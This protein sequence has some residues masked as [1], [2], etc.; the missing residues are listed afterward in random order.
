MKVSKETSPT[1]I[2]EGDKN[3][4]ESVVDTSNEYE[5]FEL[6]TEPAKRA[7]VKPLP[8]IKPSTLT[9]NLKPQIGGIKK[10]HAASHDSSPTQGS[11]ETAYYGNIG[12]PGAK[13]AS[14]LGGRGQEFNIVPLYEDVVGIW[15]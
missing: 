9:R 12:T 7:K 11:T 8:P 14:P 1:V 13:E 6:D 5:I 15:K 3:R 2:Q 10:Q 4:S